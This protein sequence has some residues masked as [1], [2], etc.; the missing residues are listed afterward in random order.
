VGLGVVGESAEDLRGVIAREDGGGECGAGSVDDPGAAAEEGA[1]P[2]VGVFVAFNG[3][4]DD[5]PKWVAPT[6][7]VASQ[8]FH[9][10]A[11]PSPVD[12]GPFE[13]DAAEVGLGEAGTAEVDLTEDRPGEVGSLVWTAMDEL[14]RRVRGR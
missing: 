5:E 4:L 11:G 8:E 14:A 10:E 6:A 1:K 3:E 12:H 13:P 9:G 2:G 7:D